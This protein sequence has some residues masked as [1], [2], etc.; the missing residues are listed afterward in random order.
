MNSQ[1]SVNVT[2]VAFSDSLCTDTLDLVPLSDVREK[3][4]KMLPNVKCDPIIFC[5]E[6][7]YQRGFL[8]PSR[9]EKFHLPANFYVI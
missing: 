9:K 2:H 4:P 1:A 6:N 5:M 3:I 8:A 7:A